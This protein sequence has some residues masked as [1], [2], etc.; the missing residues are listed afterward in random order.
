M[1]LK[2]ISSKLF[3]SVITLFI[4]MSETLIVSN[5]TT[6]LKFQGLKFQ[7]PNC[8]SLQTVLNAP[9]YFRTA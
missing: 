2:K 3:L 6:G 9:K 5:N 4:K 8:F 7:T 1:Y